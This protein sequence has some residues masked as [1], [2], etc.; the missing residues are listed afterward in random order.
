MIRDRIIVGIKDQGLS[1]CLQLDPTQTLE[2]AK[3][4]SQQRETIH[5]QQAILTSSSSQPSLSPVDAVKHQS[6][7]PSASGESKN[8]S[9]CG[10]GHHSKDLCPAKDATYHACKKKGHF[11]S[12]CYCRKAIAGII[13][14]KNDHDNS[15]VTFLNTIGCEGDVRETVPGVRKYQSMGSHFALSWRQGRNNSHNRRS[16]EAPGCKRAEGAHKTLCGLD[17]RSLEVL[18]ELYVDLS[19][20]ETI[21]SQ[22]VFIIKNQKRNLLGLPA[23]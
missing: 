6:R 2:K 10:R 12:Q 14:S 3:I 15:D 20:R 18:G 7:N 22:P 9:R 19:Y 11:K 5:E 21:I 13:T 8:C 23:I 1:K 4:M 16:D 17:Q